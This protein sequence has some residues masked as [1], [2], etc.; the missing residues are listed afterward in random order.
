MERDSDLFR[1]PELLVDHL[2]LGDVFRL[3]LAMGRTHSFS[4]TVAH[5]IYQR[6]GLTRRKG[7]SLEKLSLKMGRTSS[8]CMECGVITGCHPLVCAACSSDPDG[9]RSMVHASDVLRAYRMRFPRP[10]PKGMMRRISNLRIVKVAKT[11]SRVHW[12]C[13][14][15]QIVG[16]L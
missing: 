6:L 2:T 14:A 7:A 4:S 5:A 16:P 11:G 9:Y 15:Q 10:R 8:R 12:R 1:I 13:E 3:R